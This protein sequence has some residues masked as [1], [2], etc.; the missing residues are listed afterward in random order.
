METDPKLGTALLDGHQ[1]VAERA[2]PAPLATAA[3]ELLN[4]IGGP[5]REGYRSRWQTPGT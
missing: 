2:D 1:T 4:L 3:K 5:L